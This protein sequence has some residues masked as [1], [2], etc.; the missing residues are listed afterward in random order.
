MPEK[1][2]KLLSIFR[3]YSGGF[4][5]IMQAVVCGDHIGWRKHSRRLLLFSTD[6]SFH[7]AGDGKVIFIILMIFMIL[8][9][10]FIYQADNLL[11]K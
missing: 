11:N 2:N 1:P 4:D 7:Y 10:E 5:G 8:E 9:I 6:S 3:H